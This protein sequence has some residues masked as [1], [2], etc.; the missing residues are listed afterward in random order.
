[1]LSLIWSCNLTVFLLEAASKALVV[2]E[3]I[4]DR[5]M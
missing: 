1:M 4:L 2:K 5:I 3:F